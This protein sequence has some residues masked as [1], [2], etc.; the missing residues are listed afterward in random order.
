MRH[1][2]IAFLRRTLVIVLAGCLT[3]D[4]GA[5]AFQKRESHYAIPSPVQSQALSARAVAATRYGVGLHKESG[6]RLDAHLQYSAEAYSPRRGALKISAL[7]LLVDLLFMAY[8]AH[9]WMRIHAVLAS[10]ENNSD[11]RTMWAYDQFYYHLDHAQDDLKNAKQSVIVSVDNTGDLGSL[12]DPFVYVNRDMVERVSNDMS[13]VGM[14]YANLPDVPASGIINGQVLQGLRDFFK[15]KAAVS[16]MDPITVDTSLLSSL[17][18]EA[19]H[20]KMAHDTAFYSTIFGR[21]YAYYEG[22]QALFSFLETVAGIFLVSL[23]AGREA[24]GI[25]LILITALSGFS[26]SSFRKRPLVPH[27]LALAA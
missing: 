14:D 13:R 26:G 1:F 11:Y 18:D 20:W 16:R 2:P 23:L 4:S 8:G 17:V 15:K 9:Q 22:R 12:A 6:R 21:N 19:K 10:L 25:T 24:F 3:V 7:V 27:A 5:G